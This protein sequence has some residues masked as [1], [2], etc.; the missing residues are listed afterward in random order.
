MQPDA[1]TAPADVVATPQT[2][3]PAAPARHFTLIYK[4]SACITLQREIVGSPT[5]VLAVACGML[6][7]GSA[8]HVNLIES[9]RIDGVVPHSQIARWCAGRTEVP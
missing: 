9:E 5:D 1:S 6:R 3:L 2:T 8:K 7:D 4:P